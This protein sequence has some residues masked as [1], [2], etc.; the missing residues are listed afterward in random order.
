MWNLYAPLESL[1]MRE[2]NTQRDNDTMLTAA[3]FMRSSPPLKD[4]HYDEI[5]T[6]PLSQGFV[7]FGHLV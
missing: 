2:R 3:I 5:L 6:R 1:R 7:S 4:L